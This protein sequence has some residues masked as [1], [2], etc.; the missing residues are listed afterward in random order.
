MQGSGTSH[1]PLDACE[2]LVRDYLA[3]G[4]CTVAMGVL[5]QHYQDA[6]VS[7]CRCHL[8][9]QELAQAKVIA[10]QDARPHVRSLM[11]I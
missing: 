9:D 1:A 10:E 3:Q 2:T 11:S 4:Q 8:L 5:I 6:I 7:Y